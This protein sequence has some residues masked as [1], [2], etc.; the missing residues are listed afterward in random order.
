MRRRINVIKCRG[1]TLSRLPA[2]DN[3]GSIPITIGNR[4][5]DVAYLRTA[6]TLL[7]APEKLFTQHEDDIHLS[8]N[9]AG[10]LGMAESMRNE[11]ERAI[12]Y[13]NQE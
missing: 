5:L 1:L 4:T 9:P 6:L 10:A 11:I 8:N 13:R 12:L 7:N 3:W 2:D